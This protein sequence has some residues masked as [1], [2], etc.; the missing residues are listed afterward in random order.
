MG[1]DYTE[2]IVFWPEYNVMQIFVC[3]EPLADARASIYIDE[4]LNLYP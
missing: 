1:C 3:N 4:Y 2:E